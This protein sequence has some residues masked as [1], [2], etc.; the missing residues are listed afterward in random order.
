MYTAAALCK[1]I[2]NLLRESYADGLVRHHRRHLRS[3]HLRRREQ[4]AARSALLRGVNGVNNK[5]PEPW[6]VPEKTD[7]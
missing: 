5:T 6:T 1:F 2:D 3:V 4:A 7:K